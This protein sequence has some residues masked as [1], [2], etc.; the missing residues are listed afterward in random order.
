MIVYVER[1]AHNIPPR[2]EKDVRPVIA[3]R[4]GRLE[5]EPRRL[6]IAGLELVYRICAIVSRHETHILNVGRLVRLGDC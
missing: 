1:S 3:A 2:R 6:Y 4:E 5:V